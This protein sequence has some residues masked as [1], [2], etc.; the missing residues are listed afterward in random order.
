MLGCRWP[1]REFSSC[2]LIH[3]CPTRWGLIDDSRYGELVSILKI[4]STL[5]SRS[6]SIYDAERKEGVSERS[7]KKSSSVRA[8]AGV[9]TPAKNPVMASYLSGKMC[10]LTPSQKQTDVAHLAI[11]KELKEKM[12]SRG[13][14]FQR[15]KKTFYR[16]QIRAT[17]SKSLLHPPLSLRTIL[18]RPQSHGGR[19]GRRELFPR[20]GQRT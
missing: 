9:N 10:P 16:V 15:F 1:P 7:K 8:G 5:V 3:N 20:W 4:G 19:G 14:S 6:P 2:F 12:V 13:I 18:G 17:L 11:Q